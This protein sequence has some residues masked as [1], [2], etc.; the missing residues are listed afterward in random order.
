MHGFPSLSVALTKASPPRPPSLLSVRT[1]ALHCERCVEVRL[2]SGKAIVWNRQTGATTPLPEAY[3]LNP[4]AGA[5]P[6]PGPAV[7]ARRARGESWSR[8][9]GR[10]HM[11]ILDDR[12]HRWFRRPRRQRRDDDGEPSHQIDAAEARFR[13]R[14]NC[15]LSFAHLVAAYSICPWRLARTVQHVAQVF[16]QVASVTVRRAAAKLAVQYRGLAFCLWRPSGGNAACCPE[17]EA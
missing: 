8:N 15:V 17:R 13:T 3:A 16:L 2:F 4:P 6:A 7:G 10:N 1:A 12:L 14:Q 9:S 5:C 11:E